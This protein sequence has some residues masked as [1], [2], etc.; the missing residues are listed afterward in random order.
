MPDVI[1]RL[2]VEHLPDEHARGQHDPPASMQICTLNGA[3]QALRRHPEWRSTL[4][5][6]RLWAQSCYRTEQA[7][8]EILKTPD[9]A[10]LR[11]VADQL[12]AMGGREAKTAGAAV[13]AMAMLPLGHLLAIASYSEPCDGDVVGYS[14]SIAAQMRHGRPGGRDDKPHPTA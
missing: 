13:S 5:A 1:G 3:D 14:R 11:D 2:I 9:V 12:R 7:V 4:A 10:T 6:L 8:R